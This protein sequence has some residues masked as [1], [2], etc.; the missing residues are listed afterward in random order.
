MTRKPRCTPKPK[1]YGK[2]AL[3]N[4]LDQAPLPSWAHHQ[5]RATLQRMEVD[6]VDLVGEADAWLAAVSAGRHPPPRHLEAVWGPAVVVS[7]DSDFF[8]FPGCH[9]VPFETIEHPAMGVDGAL[10]GKVFRPQLVAKALGV[11]VAQL[12]DVAVFTG[13]DY[14]KP[15]LKELVNREGG[16]PAAHCPLP[17][18]GPFEAAEWLKKAVYAPHA[19]R[20]THTGSGAGG[21]AGSGAGSGAGRVI[22]H[23]PQAP[24]DVP[25]ATAAEAAALSF[26]QQMALVLE[27]SKTET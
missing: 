16:H 21:G 17:F 24:T 14:T 27:R 26:E 25:T 20:G 4:I 9:Y 3:K 19:A 12:V 5:V 2:S 22:T 6:V 11:T 1:K 8:C 15:V 7:K 23:A 10:A 13:N 18:A